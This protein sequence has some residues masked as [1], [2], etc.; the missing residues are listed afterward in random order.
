MNPWDQLAK[1]VCLEEMKTIMA[2]LVENLSIFESQYILIYSIRH[3]HCTLY[4]AVKCRR[5][6]QKNDGVGA[7]F[8]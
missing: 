7:N 5:S 3:I 4:V 8:I 6:I 2:R 1:V